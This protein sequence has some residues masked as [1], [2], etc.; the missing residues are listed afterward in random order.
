[1][2]E[3]DARAGEDGEGRWTG[4][5]WLAALVG[6]WIAIAALCVFLRVLMGPG[7]SVIGLTGLLLGGGW[8][9]VGIFG[10]LADRQR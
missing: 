10:I 2:S 6:G 5:Q 8:L 3:D 1:M 7:F 9:V 4:R